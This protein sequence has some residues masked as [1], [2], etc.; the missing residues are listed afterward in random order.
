MNHGKKV[1]AVLLAKETTQSK[2]RLSGVLD[3]HE[4]AALSVAMTHDTL[5]ILTRVGSVSSIWMLTQDTRLSA[6]ALK[7]GVPV[8]PENPC[9]TLLENL[10]DL[11]DKAA[12]QAFELMLVLPND[13]PLL[14]PAD[15]SALIDQHRHG[16]SVCAA[17]RDGGTN[18]LLISP[19]NAIPFLYGENSAVKHLQAASARGLVTRK[20]H[21]QSLLND[22][23][24]PSDLV[25]L[26]GQSGGIHTEFFLCENA[27]KERL[28]DWVGEAF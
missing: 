22:I 10:G 6:L 19:P 27:I 16:V 13:I 15:I 8:Y 24:T 3:A 14:N 17:Q 1:L 4:R 28:A 20:T 25:W 2:T 18:A 26:C 12:A 11:A 7:K 23:D 5:D 9:R 21:Y